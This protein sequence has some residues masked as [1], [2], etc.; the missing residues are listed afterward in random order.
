MERRSVKRWLTRTALLLGLACSLVSIS[1]AQEIV[2][3]GKVID[4]QG[5]ALPQAS[6]QVLSGDV[7]V[8]QTVSGPDGTFEI[9]AAS[10]G[11]YVLKAAGTGF[12]PV[13]QPVTIRPDSNNVVELRMLHLAI[14]ST[15]VIV[16]ADVNDLDI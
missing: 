1:N 3:K 10:P 11:K 16:T 8:F 5:D 6:I 7:M 9:K 12:Q 14:Q 15:E 13:F 4:L 2:L